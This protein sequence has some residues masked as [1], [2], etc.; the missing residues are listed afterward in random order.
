VRAVRPPADKGSA[1]DHWCP[2]RRADSWAK[3]ERSPQGGDKAAPSTTI[4]EHSAVIT[5]LYVALRAAVGLQVIEW[6]REAAAA[7]PVRSFAEPTQLSDP[8]ADSVMRRSIRSATCRQWASPRSRMP[9][10]SF[11]SA[12]KVASKRADAGPLEHDHHPLHRR[13][14]M[15]SCIWCRRLVTP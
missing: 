11:S 7:N 14:S 15:I 2:T 13:H 5:A 1:P 6:I 9:N 8:L 4:V 3:G 10:T 12:A